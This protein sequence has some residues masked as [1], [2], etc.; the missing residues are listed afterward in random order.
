MSLILSLYGFL[1]VAGRHCIKSDGL[2]DTTLS[3]YRHLLD[4]S[5]ADDE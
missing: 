2:D 4:L 5:L 1:S 3:F